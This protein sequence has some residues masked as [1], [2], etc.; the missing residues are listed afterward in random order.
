M[1]DS[2]NKFVL[3]ERI[4]L[5]SKIGGGDGFNDK[6]RQVAL[7]WV[8]ELAEQVKNELIIE[9]PLKSG[10]TELCSTSLQ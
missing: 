3:L 4:E 6:D 9:K 7:Y 8:G 5:I 10:S 1:S 2:L